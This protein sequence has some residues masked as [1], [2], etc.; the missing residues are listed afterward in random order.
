MDG[1]DPDV[2]LFAGIVEAE[3]CDPDLAVAEHGSLVVDE[4]VFVL[5]SLDDGSDGGGDDAV[6]VGDE[7]LRRSDSEWF[8]AGVD[9]DGVVDEGGYNGGIVFGY[10]LLK[11]GDELVDLGVVSEHG[12]D[13]F[14]VSSV[15]WAM[16]GKTRRLARTISLASW[17]RIFIPLSMEDVEY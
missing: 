15:L 5:L 10:G 14:V 3:A 8:G 17:V 12:V 13:G 7:G 6:V 16:A 2:G 1:A 11:V 9:L 4:E